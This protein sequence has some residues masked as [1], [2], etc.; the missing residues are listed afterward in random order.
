MIY[1]ADRKKKVLDMNNFGV[2]PNILIFITW[3]REGAA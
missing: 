3:S 1:L 2:C